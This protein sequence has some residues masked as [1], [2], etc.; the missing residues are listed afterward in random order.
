[1]GFDLAK[2]KEAEIIQKIIKAVSEKEKLNTE[3]ARKILRLRATASKVKSAVAIN[4]RFL[5]PTFDVEVG[6]EGII[7]R[8]IIHNPAERKEIE[9]VAERLAKEVSIKSELHYRGLLRG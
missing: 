8:G 6:E 9:K 3:E 2:K 7:L 5:V 1:M 4:P